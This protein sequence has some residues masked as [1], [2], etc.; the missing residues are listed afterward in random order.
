MTCPRNLNPIKTKQ[1]YEIKCSVGKGLGLSPNYQGVHMAFNTGTD[2]LVFVDIIERMLLS[3]LIIIPVEGPLHVNF[4]L[5]LYF[6]ILS[7]EYYCVLEVLEAFQKFQSLKCSDTFQLLIRTNKINKKKKS[8]IGT[9]TSLIEKL[10]NTWKCTEWSRRYLG[11]DH[12]SFMRT[13]RKYFRMFVISKASILRPRFKFYDLLKFFD[14]WF[15][16]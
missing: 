3:E 5:H 7:R 1:A 11:M 14:K 4:R 6:S 15:H 12:H 16:W 8:R 13:S 9:E 10:R 2:V